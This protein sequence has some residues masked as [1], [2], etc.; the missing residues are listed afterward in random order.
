M[1]QRTRSRPSDASDR[2]QPMI[3]VTT[4]DLGKESEPARVRSKSLEGERQARELPVASARQR[5]ERKESNPEQETPISQGPRKL[6]KSIHDESG[7]TCHNLSGS[8]KGRREK[9][10]R[11][12]RD[13]Q[14]TA[15][16]RLAAVVAG[17]HAWL[18]WAR[19]ERRSG[20]ADALPKEP[21]A[22]SSVPARRI[23][24]AAAK[25]RC[26]DFSLIGWP[27]AQD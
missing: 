22:G 14:A 23:L 13:E 18:T 2:G 1:L 15:P 11:P 3:Q 20:G 4:L 6:P 8:S 5:W 9:R 17:W 12:D 16:G 26:E 25:V 7:G 27:S 24:S 19:N 10:C 21:Y